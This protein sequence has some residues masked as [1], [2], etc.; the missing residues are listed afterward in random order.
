[1]HH[2]YNSAVIGDMVSSMTQMEAGITGVRQI[3]QC[4]CASASL[5]L[6]NKDAYPY[7]FRTV[8]NVVLFGSTLVDWVRYMGWQKFALIYTNDDVG[9]QGMSML[10]F[11][12]IH[13]LLIKC[14]HILYH[15]V[16]SAMVQKA[17]SYNLDAMT[18]IPLY[19]M[20]HVEGN[21]KE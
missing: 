7:F 16:L 14:H 11:L 10:L 6:S 21:K 13:S 18:Q 3:P 19:D 20:S 12:Y 5:K 17:S 1:M 8:G 2:V 9:Q 15:V 4:S